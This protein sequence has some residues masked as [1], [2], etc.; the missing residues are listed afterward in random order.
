MEIFTHGISRSH[1]YNLEQ[2][3]VQVSSTSAYYNTITPNRFDILL[4]IFFLEVQ[5][6][7]RWSVTRCLCA[8]FI[9]L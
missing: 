2:Y 8:I 1:F 6:L 9:I 7:L 4:F 5:G 3:S